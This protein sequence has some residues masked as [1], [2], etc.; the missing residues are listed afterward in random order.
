M[1]L[2]I[3]TPDLKLL[4]NNMINEL[5]RTNSLSLPCKLIYEGSSFTE[6]S[7][8]YIDPISGKSS[9]RYKS[10]GSLVFADGQ[11]CPNCRGLG[12]VHSEA[13]DLIDLLIIFDYKYWLNFNSKVHSPNGLIQTI[14][15]LNDFPKIQKCSKLIVDTN[16]SNY[17]E[18]YYQRNSDP[19]P[20]GFGESSY[21]FTYWKKI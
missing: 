21:F 13:Y 6:C 20:A 4:Y 19:E 5:L 16:L 15:K 1:S 2:N 8:C 10:G 18:N 12:G 11:I 3:I 9:N 17:T 7:N 14:N